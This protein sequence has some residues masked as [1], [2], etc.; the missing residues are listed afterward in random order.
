MLDDLKYIHEKDVHDLLGVAGWQCAQLTHPFKL[1]G[2]PPK[3]ITNIVYA[4]L[5]GS[6]LAALT[7]QSWPQLPVPLEIVR[8]YDLP[9][10]VDE[11]TL[12]IVASYSG[13][14]EETLSA[15]AQA[16]ARHAQ[17]AVIT[18]GGKMQQ[19]AEEKGYML[20]QLPAAEHP[21]YALLYNLRALL[22]VLAR[23][24][25]VDMQEV[26]PALEQA[27]PF[28]EEAVKQW[29]ATVPARDN[30]A[31]QLAQELMG[32]SVVIY[33]GPKLFPAAYK[34]KISTNENAKHVAWTNQYPEFNHNEFIGWSEQPVDKPYAIIDL[35]SPLEHPR[36][37]KRFEVTERLL[38]GKRP[39]PNIVTPAGSNLLEQ[40]LWTALY[41]DFVTIYLA[42]LSGINPAPV[43]L[44][45]KFKKELDS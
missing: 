21:R 44:V 35:R 23:A 40:L 22:D 18:H 36:I 14:T 42:L 7:V 1:T 27:V 8:G 25:C 13:N 24:G 34:W 39:A 37:Q 30:P 43:E 3:K 6:G 32:K 2:T 45:D 4:A 29:G 41:S 10:Y 33:S 5:G 20:A 28:L 9:E 17:I 12:V 31:K 16:E 26:Q 19:V 38:S 11:N 15:L